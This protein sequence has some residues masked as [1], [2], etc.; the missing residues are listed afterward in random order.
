[1]FV[2]VV[3]GSENVFRFCLFDVVLIKVLWFL[4]YVNEIVGYVML[5][6]IGFLFI[7]WRLI[8]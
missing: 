8:F 1:M 6:K 5:W 7:F 3:E 4:Y 2:V